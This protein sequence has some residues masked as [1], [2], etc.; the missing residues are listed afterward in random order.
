MFLVLP[1]ILH[2]RSLEEVLGTQS[3]SSL[4][5][6]EQKFDDRADVLL[7]IHPRMMAM[8]GL[9]LRSLRV[10]DPLRLGDFR[11]ERGRSLARARSHRL[12]PTARVSQI[13]SGRPR[14]LDG[15]AKT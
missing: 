3:G 13:Y 14:S 4:R 6:F 1:L 2:S 7:A 10:R 15:G 9:T 12:E 11:V 5:K 8:R